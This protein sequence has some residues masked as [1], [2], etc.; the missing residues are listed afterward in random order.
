MNTLVS[1]WNCE[2]V[3]ILTKEENVIL[4]KIEKKIEK[5][6]E[7][8][9]FHP[10]L[11]RN[12]FEKKQISIRPFVFGIFNV[13][14][15]KKNLKIY[16]RCNEKICINPAHFVQTTQKIGDRLQK[17][18]WE[19]FG[20]PEKEIIRI[21]ELQTLLANGKRDESTGSRNLENGKD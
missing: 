1:F 4:R 20:K 13:E 6:S 19:H 16:L 17:I 2:S 14:L 3:R 8:C 9:F 18:G 12:P 15:S 10:Q 7:G 21:F 5:K 11:V